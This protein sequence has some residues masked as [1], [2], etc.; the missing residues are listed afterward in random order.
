MSQF[1]QVHVLKAEFDAALDL[2]CS[3]VPMRRGHWRK[4][5]LTAPQRV[6]LGL[7]DCFLDGTCS[8]V[9]WCWSA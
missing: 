3:F 4:L 1:S 6:F 8:A 7:G 5:A 9:R 2:A